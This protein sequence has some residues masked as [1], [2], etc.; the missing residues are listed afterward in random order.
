MDEMV[1]LG[2]HYEDAQS[3]EA[4][5]AGFTS[6]GGIRSAASRDASVTVLAVDDSGGPVRLNGAIGSTSKGSVPAAGSLADAV[7]VGLLPGVALRDGWVR[8]DADGT[9]VGRLVTRVVDALRPA[10]LQALAELIHRRPRALVVVIPQAALDE[11]TALTSRAAD[12]VTA[13]FTV[14]VDA[15]NTE[16]QAL[17]TI[18]PA[19]GGDSTAS[20]PGARPA[21]R[22]AP[23]LRTAWRIGLVLLGIVLLYSAGQFILQDGGLLVFQLIMAWL[24]SIAMEPAVGRLTRHLRRGVATGLVMAGVVVAAVGFFAAFG[25]LLADQIRNLVTALPGAVEALIDWINATFDLSLDSAA[26]ASQLQVSPEQI[27]TL[28]AEV[29]G[30][31]LGAIAGLVGGIF[32]MFTIGLFIFYFSA[33]APRFKRWVARLL[34]QRRQEVFLVVW[35]LAVQKTGGYVAARIVLAAISG[36]LTAV[37]LLLI[38]MDY[39]LALGIWTGVVAQFV[40]TIGTYIAIALPVVVGLTSADP[41][42]GVLALAFAL[43]YQQVENLTIEPKISANAVDMHP[44]V[45]FASVLL[46]AALFGVAGAFCAVPVAALGLAL[47]EIYSRSY[48]LLPQFDSPTPPVARQGRLGRKRAQP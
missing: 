35:D 7:L 22:A 20:G 5:L 47:F 24:A 2:C 4:D 17:L 27:A 11:T 43:V 21:S 34:P 40:P 37:F 18:P 33:D 8:A 29:A 23:E 28:G 42:D 48:E 1:V 31:L 16:A 38:G 9:D 26:L 45:A 39:W 19:S 6:D 41:V 30:G 14:D 15:L 44:A 25:S 32:S 46:G 36:S 10:D 12:R 3:A 13:R